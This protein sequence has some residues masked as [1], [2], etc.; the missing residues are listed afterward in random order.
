MES[1]QINKLIEILTQKSRKLNNEKLLEVLDF[2]DFLGGKYEEETVK[3]GI[4]TLACN[5][6]SFRFL[7]EEPEI[8]SLK[9]VK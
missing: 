5:S 8:Y 3:K 7:S 4:E 2:V 6:E 9:D 1:E